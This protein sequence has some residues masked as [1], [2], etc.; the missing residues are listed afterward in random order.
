MKPENVWVGED[1]AVKLM[2]FGIARL[3]TP[4]RFTTTGV[5]LGT[6]YYMAPEQ[7]KGRADVDG[8]ADQYAVGVVLYELLTGEVPQGVILPRGSGGGACRRGCRRR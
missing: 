8:R 1:G 5:A 6:A 3:L 7:L 2:D 4:A